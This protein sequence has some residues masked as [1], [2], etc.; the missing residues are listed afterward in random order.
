MLKDI[1]VHFEE[2]YEKKELFKKINEIV[3]SLSERDRTIVELAFGFKN[4]KVYMQHEISKITG[5]SQSYIS[6]ITSENVSKIAAILNK[7]GYIELHDAQIKELGLKS[8]Y[9]YLKKYPKEKVDEAVKLLPTEV[10]ELI[11]EKF[12]L[13]QAKQKVKLISEIRTLLK[14]KGIK[15]NSTPVVDQPKPLEDSK[16]NKLTK[17]SIKLDG[18]ESIKQSKEILTV[19]EYIE[20]LEMLKNSGFDV[21]L[22]SLS[23]KDA[24]VVSL[25]L[26][27]VDNKYFSIESFQNF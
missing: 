2:D 21:V 11:E 7:K 14:G 24:I 26:G 17:S 23:P 27:Y 20:M 9:D 4:N 15:Y 25:S 16:I 8:I 18:S 22:K 19:K 13:L 10:Q 6:R 5:L 12:Y 3:D 1:N